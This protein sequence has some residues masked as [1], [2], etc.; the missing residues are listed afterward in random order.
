MRPAG[1]D[2][3]GTTVWPKEWVSD[4]DEGAA[5]TVDIYM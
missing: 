4:I 1:C 2:A 5:A 3:V